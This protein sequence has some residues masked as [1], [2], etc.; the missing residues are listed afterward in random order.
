MKML[1]GGLGREQRLSECGSC[2]AP[3]LSPSGQVLLE[4]PWAACTE[5]IPM[6]GV[7]GRG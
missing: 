4:T 2:P 6:S 7:M 1:G 5:I 3:S